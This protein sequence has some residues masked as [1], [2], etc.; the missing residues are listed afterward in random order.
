MNCG[1]PGLDRKALEVPLISEPKRHWPAIGLCV[2]RDPKHN[3]RSRDAPDCDTADEV[4]REARHVR[5]LPPA[6]WIKDEVSTDKA[7]Q[8]EP[9]EDLKKRSGKSPNYAEAFMLTFTPRP[10]SPNIQLLKSSLA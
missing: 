1:N 2:G 4:R 3:H 10:P 7:L 9:K 5:K 6:P 8:I